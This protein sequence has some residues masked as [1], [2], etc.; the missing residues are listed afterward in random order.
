MN[1]E[2][3]KALFLEE[4]RDILGKIEDSLVAL[5]KR[6]EDRN[7]VNEVFRGLHTIKGSGAMFGFKEISDFTHRVENLFDEIRQ[8]RIAVDSAI[9]DIGLRSTD[10][11]DRLLEG[12]GAGEEGEGIFRAIEGIGRFES[13]PVP[14]DPKSQGYSSIAVSDGLPAEQGIPRVYR[15]SFRPQ[16]Q[17]LQRGVRIESL[18]RELAGLG[19]CHFVAT[20][21]SLPP[22]EELD[23]TSMHLAWTITVSTRE[24]LAALRSVFMFVEDYSELSIVALAPSEAGGEITTPKLGEILVDRGILGADDVEALRRAQKPFGEVAIDSGKVAKAHVAAALAEQALVRGA[25]AECESRRESSTVRVRKEKLDKLIDLVGELVILEASLEQEAGKEATGIFSAISENLGRLAS[26][27]R[28]TVMSVRMVPL[29]ES[30]ASFKRLVRDLAQS[31]GKELE[32]AISGGGTEL[33]KNVIELLKDPLVHIIR[34]SADHGIEAPAEREKAG[35]P[36]VGTVSI[37]ARQVGSRV[38]ITVAD[39]GAGLDLA[40]IRARAVERGLLEPG[41]VEEERIRNMIFEPGFSTAEKATGLSGR[42]VGMDVVKRNIERLRGEVSL[43]SA[44]GKG[45]TVTLSIPLTLVII[46]GLLVRVAGRDYVIT[47]SQVEECVDLTGSVRD[48]GDGESIADLRGASVPILSLRDSLGIGGSFPG[49]PR[50][51]VVNHEGVRVGLAVDAVIG[52]KQVVIKPLSGA[53]RRIKVIF[54]A[55]ILGDGSVALLLDVAEIIKAGA[56]KRSSAP[57][58]RS[59]A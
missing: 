48:R 54:G 16:P 40:K 30:F 41:V 10:C 13:A 42:G 24:S 22:L 52:K 5:E 49:V 44:S 4:A 38:E 17:I 7:L 59:I 32:L 20:F 6:P 53:V 18:F 37:G 9:V 43:E 28:D 11:I 23:P 33:D 8:G 26:D 58:K 47:L 56:G 2:D 3:N 39:D 25:N 35:K 51:V 29:E 19:H 45:M 36:R 46:E 27:L 12:G 55:T 1:F 34:N 21:D 15:V 50:L 57:R 14:A 31:T